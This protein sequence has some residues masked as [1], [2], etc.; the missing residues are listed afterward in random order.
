MRA[1][2]LL[3]SAAL[4]GC[5]LAV[6]TRITQCAVDADC[7]H[8]DDHPRCQEGLC[9]P[10]GLGPAGCFPGTPAEPSQFANHCTTAATF[11]FD[12]CMRLGMCDGDALAAGF[13]TRAAPPDLGTIPPPVTSQPTP[14][15][16]CSAVAPNLIYITGSTNLPPLLKAVQPLLYAEHPPYVAIFAPQTSCK[17]AGSILDPDPSKHLI[18]NVLDNYA[19]YYDTAGAQQL[20][21]LDPAGNIVDVG[22]SDVYPDSCNYAIVA[23]TADYLGPIQ[24]ITLVVPSGSKQTV[25]SAEAAHLVFGAG[26]DGGRAFPWSDPRYYFTRSSGTG[27]MQLVARSVGIDPAMAWGID[28]LSAANLV[29]SM[30]AVD[31]SVA[32]NAIGVVSSDF[33][34]RSRANLRVLAFQQRGQLHGYLPDATATAF[35]KANVRDGHYPIW[36]A[37]H[38]L[39]ATQNGVPSAA[40]RAL[41]TRLTV[42]KLERE[43]VSAIIASGFVP[44]CAMKV[45]HASELGPLTGFRPE[46]GCGCFYDHEVNGK[47]S[48]TACSGP[49]D[50]PGNAPACNYGYC[51]VQ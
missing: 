36:G 19:L 18:K 48:C 25:I 8:F 11:D 22:E 21:L 27:T 20:C 24:A 34:D 7:D 40:A 43:T 37:I 49:G 10:S 46:F 12:N 3:L 14:A 50:C 4:A 38:L 51:E 23:D 9:V 42:P 13:A 30:E 39:A 2:W 26:G 45:D 33:A 29:A 32:N 35:D 44:S 16:N 47:T 1:P 28:R 17:G 31:P 5:S 15:E 6:D 41:I